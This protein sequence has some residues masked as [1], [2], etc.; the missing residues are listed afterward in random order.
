MP[1]TRAAC[2]GLRP[3]ATAHLPATPRARADTPDVMRGEETQL[4]GVTESDFTGLVCI[5]GTHSKW[6]KIE[7]GRIVAFSPDTTDEL[8][9]VTAQHSIRVPAFEGGSPPDSQAFREGLS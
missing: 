9:S 6:I 8:F 5:P 1:C 3:A 4:L 7:D 2:G